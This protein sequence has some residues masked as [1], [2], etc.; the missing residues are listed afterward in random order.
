MKRNREGNRWRN[1][2][3]SQNS[4]LPWRLGRRFGRFMGSRHFII[5]DEQALQG[6]VKLSLEERK[7][8]FQNSDVMEELQQAFKQRIG[9]NRIFRGRR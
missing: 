7:W 2:G 6:K 9:A 4:D 5:D 8:F 3:V 1:R